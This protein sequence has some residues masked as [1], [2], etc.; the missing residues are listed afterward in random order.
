MTTPSFCA[1]AAPSKSVTP[2]RRSDVSDLAALVLEEQLGTLR[3][4]DDLRLVRAAVDDLA[5]L[6]GGGQRD[7]RRLPLGATRTGVGAGD[8]PLRGVTCH[9]LLS[10][11]F[12]ATRSALCARGFF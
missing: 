3:V 8:L 1:R 7:G 6:D 9:G 4:G 2:C 11:V 12:S 10:S 5:V